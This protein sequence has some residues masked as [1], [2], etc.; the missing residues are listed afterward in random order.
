MLY[1]LLYKLLAANEP[2]YTEAH[3]RLFHR[4]LD[5][6]PSWTRTS[7]ILIN[8]Q[9]LYQLSYRGIRPLLFARP[10]GASSSTP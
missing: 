8:S 6:S 2:G 1:E 7:D 3:E 4:L 9:T 10:N 5:G